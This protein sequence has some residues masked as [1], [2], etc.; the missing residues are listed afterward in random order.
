VS[1]LAP[2]TYPVTITNDLGC[3]IDTT[4][5][6]ADIPCGNT[7]D[8]NGNLIIYS[9]YD[10]GILTINVDQNIPN[11]K[12]GICTYE[13]IQVTF[14]GPFVGNITQVIYAGMN[15]NQNNNNCGLGN[16]PTS[17]TG[18][19]AGIVTISPPMNPHLVG[20][21][22]VHGNGAG[23]WGGQMI[24]VAG[25]CDTTV[26]AG[27][28]NTPDEV[29]YYFL[30]ATG[31]TLLYHQT[32]YACWMNETV[33]VTAGGNCCILPPGS[34]PC[35]TITST[36]SG[37][38]NVLCNGQSTGAATV[39]ANGGTGPYTYTWTPGNLNGGTQSGLAANVYTV[40][41][42]DANLCPGSATVTI[43]QPA[44]LTAPT[45]SVTA[46]PTCSVATGTITVTSPT[47]AAGTTYTVAGTAPVVAPQT[48]STGI[49]SGLAPGTY[50]VMATVNGCNSPLTSMTVN[51]QPAGPAAPTAS[52]TTLATC[53]A[54]TATITVTVPAP[55]AGTTYTVTG[56][57]PVVAPQTNTTGVFNGLNPGTYNVTTTVGGCTS[58]ATV[59]VVSPPAGA[60]IIS[61]VSTND[62]TCNGGS[63]GDAIVSGSGGTGT[64]TYTWTPGNLSGTNQTGLSAG[65][66]SVQVTDQTG[67]S[68]S[69]TVTIGEPAAVNITETIT[70]ANC[71][72][73]DGSISVVVA[74]GT[75][76]YTYSWSPGG[77]TASSI[78][79]LTPGNYS[80]SVTDQSGCSATENYVVG[81][82]G[83][84]AIVATPP[85]STID[86][87]DSVQLN[88]T[89]GTTYSWAPTTGLSCSTC[90]NPIA[91]PLVTT[92]YIVTGT[93]ASGCTGAD[94]LIVIVLPYIEP[95]G[96]L[97]IPTVLAPDGTGSA[98]NKSI[99]VYG[100]CVS[101][102]TFAIYSRWGEKVFETS[103]TDLSECWDGTYKGKPM[104]AG[105]FAYKLIVTLTNGD[106]YEESGN[107]T[108]VR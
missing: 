73:A 101:E 107:I 32:Q 8:P 82:I 1:N 30:N 96:E 21:T 7:C 86:E 57:S 10:G 9:N 67:C 44:A 93:D 14:T 63:D 77:S 108:L 64:L 55:A 16:F 66:Y 104:N 2:G 100:G 87:G 76:T 72:S 36:I 42:V 18:V 81:Q 56:T 71:G 46:Q 99:C 39:T 45:A 78:T 43:T 34:T 11:L 48:N 89:G 37:Q 19:P 17:V 53:S 29:V 49:F 84:L 3:S 35:P 6:L 62:V 75:G 23:P 38:T 102:L 26:N 85:S 31:G 68:N 91:S 95:C 79:A 33:N 25:L 4:I 54:P 70:S 103:N 98:Q 20:Y 47:P 50:S 15:S 13:P 27:G 65:S 28:G 52:V 105:V 51:A 88:V 58:T 92:T 22:P 69:T 40:N 61:V 24:G 74:G 80:V 90:D 12:V 5:V 97:F 59:I 106:S 94:T 83:S 60:P 41:I